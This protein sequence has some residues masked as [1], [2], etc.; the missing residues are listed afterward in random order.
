MFLILCTDP[1][2][3]AMELHQRQTGRASSGLKLTKLAL[4]VPQNYFH[5][6]KQD[7]FHP[8]PVTPQWYPTIIINLKGYSFKISQRILAPYQLAAS[9]RSFELTKISSQNCL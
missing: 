7:T 8:K 4:L 6:Q 1:T 2:T 9:T 5:K 3:N